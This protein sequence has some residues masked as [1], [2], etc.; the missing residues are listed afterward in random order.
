MVDIIKNPDR[1][2]SG[3]KFSGLEY[4]RADK[5]GNFFILEHCPNKRTVLCQL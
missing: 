2:I 5:Y 4:L 3:Y 1:W